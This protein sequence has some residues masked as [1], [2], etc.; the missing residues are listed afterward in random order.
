MTGPINEENTMKKLILATLCFIGVV[1]SAFAE[2]ITVDG[3]IVD[4]NTYTSQLSVKAHNVIVRNCTFLL[5]I[6][7]GSYGLS[8]VYYD[9]NSQPRSTNLLVE[10]CTFR[11]S[12]SSAVYVQYARVI[13]NDIQECGADAIK[14][15]TK[16]HCRIIGNYI[17]RIGR[18][19]GS[20]ADGLQMTGGSDVMIAYNHFDMPVSFADANGYNSNA[21]IIIQTQLAPVERIL[22]WGNH[23]QGGNYTV[24][25]TEHAS[26]GIPSPTR[27]RFNDNTFGTDFRFGVLQWDYDPWI[28]VNGN[29]WDDGTFMDINTWDDWPNQ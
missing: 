5:P 11:G 3:T 15:S 28:Q 9:S 16:G 21:C 6:N 18:N 26:G 14:I 2:T 8:N 23:F 20:H 10:N 4:G 19:S 1:S 27:I 25:I 17:A 24:Y 13:G 29:V 7:A 22:I 12:N